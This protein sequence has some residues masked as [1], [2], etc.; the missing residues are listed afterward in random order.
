MI[1]AVTL[2]LGQPQEYDSLVAL[3]QRY[4]GRGDVVIICKCEDD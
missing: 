2:G 3:L 1:V 4:S